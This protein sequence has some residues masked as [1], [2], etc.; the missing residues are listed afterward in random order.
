MLKKLLKKISLLLPLILLYILFISPNHV[1]ADYVDNIKI[2]YDG[3]V[4]PDG[5]IAPGVRTPNFYQNGDISDMTMGRF[6]NTQYN[7]SYPYGGPSENVMY[8]NF[9]LTLNNSAPQY[10]SIMDKDNNNIISQSFSYNVGTPNV[11]AGAA[12]RYIEFRVKASPDLEQDISSITIKP[13]YSSPTSPD[14]IIEHKYENLVGSTV[15]NWNPSLNSGGSF[16]DNDPNHGK[17]FIS[18]SYLGFGF[19]GSANITI[20][21]KKPE[22]GKMAKFMNSNSKIYTYSASNTLYPDVDPKIDSSIRA[23]HPVYEALRIF[24]PKELNRNNN[25]NHQILEDEMKDPYIKK[26]KD[27]YNKLFHHIPNKFPKPKFTQ[28]QIN[29]YINRITKERDDGINIITNEAHAM[30]KSGNYD[31]SIFNDFENTADDTIKKMDGENLEPIPKNLIQI[32][33]VPDLDFGNRFIP[34]TDK[35]YNLIKPTEVSIRDVNYPTWNLNL[36]IGKL[37]SKDG[38]P[39][40]ASYTMN[41][42]EYRTNESMPYYSYNNNS[43]DIND[44]INIHKDPYDKDNVRMNLPYS[45]LPGDYNGVATW[46]L[47]YTPTNSGGDSGGSSSGDSG[48]SSNDYQQ[49][50][51]DG[52]NTGVADANGNMNYNDKGSGNQSYN[53]GYKAGYSKSYNA[54]KSYNQGYADG[55]AKGQSDGS[56]AGN[57]GVPSGWHYDD[58]GGNNGNLEYSKGYKAGYSNGYSNGYNNGYNSSSNS[59]SSGY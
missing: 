14:S 17:V 48:G 11:K 33:S 7:I 21:L 44:T 58:S 56:S 23:Y 8:S 39:L 28:D 47:S 9:S 41:N 55:Q 46:N 26:I 27:E 5:Y 1:F 53:Q 18:N 45:T 38:N 43:K 15:G 54:R 32:K 22:E 30:E 4:P 2:P 50:Y 29:D 34:D 42:T 13:N 57:L 51:K 59:S 36:S 19:G 49:G 24:T 6:S 25:Y 35:K 12:N 40:N 10:N 3:Y 52:Q 20:H 37:T 31:N 16:Y